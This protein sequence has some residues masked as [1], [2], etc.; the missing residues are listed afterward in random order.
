MKPDTTKIPVNFDRLKRAVC[1]WFVKFG[2][3]K[4]EDKYIKKLYSTLD[5]GP[6]KAPKKVK[7]ALSNY[8]TLVTTV[9]NNRWKKEHIINLEEKK[10]QNVEPNQKRTEIHCDCHQ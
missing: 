3:K 2:D 9:F 8:K 1:L 10:D 6:P 5:W 4:E 7:L